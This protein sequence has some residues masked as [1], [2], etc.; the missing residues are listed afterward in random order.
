MKN[1]KIYK[2]YSDFLTRENK[3]WNGVSP[4]FAKINPNY[5]KENET[6]NGCWNCSD[7]FDCSGCSDCSRCSGCSDCYDCSDKKGNFTIP[8]I[9]NIHN[10]I[11]EVVTSS[12][13]ALKMSKWHTCETEHCRAGWV[14]TLAG[15]EGKKLEEE[16]ST[17][18]AAMQIYK[19]SSPIRV[20]PV[21]F[22]DSNDK[23]ME[24]IKRCAEEEA[25]LKK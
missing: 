12:P 20:S 5:E 23:A 3:D 25:N 22:F 21:R 2:T 9:T 7:C 18:F 19:A 14:V 13:D 6:N 17:L 1:T 16:T 11:L 4:Q 15:E 10:A 24:D 8:T